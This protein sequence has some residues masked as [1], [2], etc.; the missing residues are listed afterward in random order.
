MPAGET[1]EPLATN[2]LSSTATSVT[3]SSISGSY[4]DL[5]IVVSGTI[6]SGSYLSFRFNGDTGNN[7]GNTEFEQYST[8]SIASA[9]NT[10]ASYL[11]NG[12][13]QTGQSNSTTHIQN[14]SNTTTFKTALTRA[15]FT[16]SGVKM[17]VGTW[18]STAAITS[19]EIG[20]GGGAS[21]FQIGTIFT[22]Y[23]IK[24]A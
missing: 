22:L 14:Y 16:T 18:R 13:F 5:V 19:I 9:R 8:S 6:S 17:S 2:T 7:Y 12:S 10:N 24:A 4:T 23:G 21:T 15:N 11:Y 20:N 1:Y 3:F